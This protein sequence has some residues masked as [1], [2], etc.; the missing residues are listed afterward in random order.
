MVSF[1]TR[2]H[3]CGNQGW[4]WDCL[5]SLLLP[6]SLFLPVLELSVLLRFPTLGFFIPLIIFIWARWRLTLQFSLYLLAATVP[7]VSSCGIQCATFSAQK[8][9]SSL[10]LSQGNQHLLRGL[11][12]SEF[13][14]QCPGPC[15]L[16]LC[17]ALSLKLLTLHNSNLFS[18]LLRL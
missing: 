2:T 1:S 5:F 3:G 11:G 18:L 16:Q 10:Y 12:A 6:H 8:S 4:Q 7:S 9:I 15:E 14:P 13:Q 17:V